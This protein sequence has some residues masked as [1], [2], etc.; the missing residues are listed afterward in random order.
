MKLSRLLSVY[1]E[2]HINDL[3]I[4]LTGYTLNE[5]NLK[6]SD[7]EKH[8]KFVGS[9]P[10]NASV[11]NM[12]RKGEKGLVERITNG[13]DAVIEKKV[14]ENFGTAPSTSTAVIKKAFP[15]YYAH[16]EKIRKGLADSN[17]VCDAGNQVMVAVSDGSRSSRPTYDVVD[18]GT[19]IRG[20]EFASTILSI[21]RGNK[22]SSDKQYLIG[23]FGQGGSTSLSFAN[24]TIIISKVDNV[25]YY[26][27][28][29][30]VDLQDYKN[31][32]Y[33]YLTIDEQIPTCEED[34]TTFDEEWLQQFVN[35]ESGTLVRMVEMNISPE[36]S[37]LDASKPH[38]LGDLI[39]TE[40][41]DVGLPVSVYENRQ[42]FRGNVH[43]QNRSSFGSA[44]KLCTWKK[45]LKDEYSGSLNIDFENKPYKI[46]YYAILPDNE[47]DWASDSKCR[48]TFESINIYD[49]PVIYTVNG[50]TVSTEGFTRIKN[51]GLNQLRYRLLIVINLDLLGKEKYK[52]FTTD[53]SQI[54]VTEDSKGLLTEVISKICHEPKLI[55]LNSRIAGL[56]LSKGLD[57]E[58]VA[59]IADQV[60]NEYSQYVKHGGMVKYKHPNKPPK[61]NPKPKDYA[62]HIVEL[63][64]VS[65]KN[66]FYKD[67]EVSFML[68]T[69]AEKYVNQSAHIYAFID[70]F[71]TTALLPT[72]SKGM[73]SWKSTAKDIGFG[74]HTLFFNY[75]GDH[76]ES[77]ESDPFEF[78]V[79]ESDSEP[80][81]SPIKHSKI[82]NIEIGCNPNQELIIDLARNDEESKIIVTY[83][84]VHE[85]L[86]DQVYG[87]HAK[88][89][90]LKE[91]TDRYLKPVILFILFMGD[92]FENMESTVDK[93]Q[94]VVNFI[95]AQL[96][97]YNE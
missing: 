50:Q 18:K 60:K 15:D 6:Y 42:S 3:C 81:D 88:E 94:M 80:D 39:N 96:T 47:Q 5:K 85:M 13:I 66:E 97:T 54:K 9:N 11:I 17:H 70:D 1:K 28:V 55:E 82:P 79:F 38:G 56:A 43:S 49:D 84:N 93:N 74:K 63:T 27:V 76:G 53:R 48:I 33:V 4:E 40:L 72:F 58:D 8:W 86:Y 68:K 61:P 34:I 57:D 75:Y 87:K 73:I 7:I 10:S 16:C 83:N 77:L 59:R 19:G 95:K 23:A 41:F 14:S 71:Q 52:F 29:K 24:A 90:D 20:P 2:G 31:V 26:T 69:G 89:S 12:L 51:G 91:V 21:N 36:I 44:L 65:T 35:S 30:Q 25:Y 46:D 67:E 32:A 45:Y 62:D 37:G 92:K 64:I 78:E 22:L